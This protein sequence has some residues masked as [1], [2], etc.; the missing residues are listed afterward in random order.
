MHRK[1]KN[2]INNNSK[3]SEE[4]KEQTARMVIEGGKSST[5][6]AKELGLDKNKVCRWV[7]DY[8]KKHNLPSYAQE[9]G[10]VSNHPHDEAD[11]KRKRKEKEKIF[12]FRV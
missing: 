11:F 12:I 5:K 8:R 3:Y 10:I 7:R 6:I 4:M 9:K 1:G 2:M